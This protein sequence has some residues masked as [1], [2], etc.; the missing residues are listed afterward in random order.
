LNV[1]VIRKY[2]ARPV[3]GR[4]WEDAVWIRLTETK[5]GSAKAYKCELGKI[6]KKEKPSTE[7][8]TAHN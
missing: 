5:L 4:H 1:K 2:E 3:T 7:T 6:E 8:E